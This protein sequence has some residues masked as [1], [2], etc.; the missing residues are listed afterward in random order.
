MCISSS[1]LSAI[2]RPVVLPDLNRGE[3]ACELASTQQNAHRLWI[4]IDFSSLW[5]LE[6]PLKQGCRLHTDSLTPIKRRCQ[7]IYYPAR[8]ETTSSQSEMCLCISVC[9]LDLLFGEIIVS[10]GP[11][12][13][14]KV[15]LTNKSDSYTFEGLSEWSRLLRL[16]KC[17]EIGSNPCEILSLFKT[18][19][20]NIHEEI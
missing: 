6:Y 15:W 1:I 17:V 5:Q 9:H 11:C 16:R 19:E 20:W 2:P 12:A 3:R 4:N 7:K 18:F 13:S 14:G 8:T 10:I